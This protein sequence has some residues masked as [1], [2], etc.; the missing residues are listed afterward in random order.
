MVTV[1]EVHLFVLVNCAFYWLLQE[2]V[3]CLVH[4]AHQMVS[5]SAVLVLDDHVAYVQRV[6]IAM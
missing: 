2:M 5:T 4:E 6:E 1:V 3:V